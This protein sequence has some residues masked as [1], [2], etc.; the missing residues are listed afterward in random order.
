MAALTAFAAFAASLAV[1]ELE[2][3]LLLEALSQRHG[4]DFRDYDRQ[5]V[6][7]KLLAVMAA[8]EL[9]T[10]SALQERVLHEPGAASNV[11]RALCVAPAALFDNPDWAR[12]ARE[13]LGA[14]LRPV[15]VPRVWLDRVRRRGRSLDAGNRAARGRTACAHR[16]LRHGGQRRVA[17]RGA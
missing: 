14:A 1:E 8:R 2:I 3:D 11:L 12:Q 7:K 5:V 15:A 6:R 4:F 13:V 16:D 9:K 10:V 17:G